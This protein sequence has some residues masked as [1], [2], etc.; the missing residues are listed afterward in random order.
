MFSSPNPDS[1][2]QGKII[3]KGTI[4]VPNFGFYK[5]SIITCHFVQGELMGLAYPKVYEYFDYLI[6]L[7]SNDTNWIPTKIK[8]FLPAK[9]L[10]KSLASFTLCVKCSFRL[11]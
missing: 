11:K 1:N 3:L 2:V 4:N 8:S 5:S 7:L 10:A 6:G 9:L